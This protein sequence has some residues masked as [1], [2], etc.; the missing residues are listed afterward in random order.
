VIPARVTGWNGNN[1][2]IAAAVIG[3][4]ENTN[5]SYFHA[6]TRKEWKFRQQEKVDR[7]TIEAE[8]V[9]EITVISRIDK[10]GVENAVEIHPAG[11][12]VDFVF[13]S[14][15]TRDFDNS[16]IVGHD[17]GLLVWKVS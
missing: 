2:R 1:L 15:P 11:L 17:G 10:G 14:A 3:H 8:R 6:H 13:V 7:V 4:V 5:W 9:L 16:G 12:V